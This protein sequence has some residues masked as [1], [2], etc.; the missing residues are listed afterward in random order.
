MR[1][2]RHRLGAPGPIAVVLR[3]WW[4]NVRAGEIGAAPIVV[5]IA[6]ITVFFYSKN[7]NFVSATN[8]NNLIVQTA[9]TATIAFGVVF[10]LLL[11]EIDL[12]VGFV[13]GLAGITV[14]ELQLPGSSHQLPGVVAI[15]LAVLVGVAIGA[16]QGAFVSFLGVPSFVVTL[17][18][19]LAWE[20]LILR[21]LPQGV[22]VIQND[23]V[24]NVANYFFSHTGG[25][26]IAAIVSGGYALVVVHGILSRRRL[27]LPGDGLAIGVRQGR[28]SRRGRGSDRVLVEHGPAPGRP[29][30][31]R[32]R[33]PP[34]RHLDLRLEPDDVWTA[35]LRGRGQ[36]RGSPPCGNQRDPGSD[37]RVHDLGR[38][39]RPRRRRLRLAPALGRPQRRRRHD[40]ARHDRRSGDRRCQPLRGSRSCQGARCSAR[41][42]SP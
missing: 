34:P 37:D 7:P 16:F 40:P 9:G 38:D 20:G 15:L 27:G 28:R 10:V 12:S 5:A 35:C 14:A 3:R 21:E 17:A 26:I 1:P 22:I 11:G 29:V 42:S 2:I 32:A 6:L 41:S 4:E 24:N 39:G 25:W 30:R 31:G 23:T 19:S 13:S 8:L 36:R 18:G 33:R